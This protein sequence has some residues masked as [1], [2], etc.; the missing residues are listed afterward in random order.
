MKIVIA[1][2]S[3]KESMTA[4][5]VAN[6]IESG[7]KQVFPQAEYIKIPMADGGEGTVQSIV[8]ATKGHI[9]KLEVTGPLG[10]PLEA[11]YGLS[12]DNSLA[13]IEM[14]ASS[15]L[16]KVP[17][18]K[19]NPL[20]TTTWGLGELIKDALDEGV[21]EIIL[22]LG[23]SATIDGGIG[24]AQ[25]L[26][27]K[28][29][30]KNNDQIKPTGEGLEDIAKIDLSD[31]HHRI[32]EVKVRVASDVNNPLTGT[33]GAAYIYGPQKG[34]TAEQVEYLDRNL[35][36]LGECI[37]NDLGLDI[38]EMAGA[39]A[40]G[41]LGAGLVAFLN[42][43]LE[44]GGKLVSDLLNLK[45]RLEGADLVITGEGGI[46]HQTIFGKTPII[47]SRTAKKL[48]IPTIAFSGI[49]S[50]GFESI[51]SEGINAVFSIVPEL[52]S[53]DEALENGYKNLEMTAKNV[54][55]VLKLTVYLNNSYL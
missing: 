24:M 49:I 54:A 20:K 28:I 39:G 4:L 9:K 38:E 42:A 14:A 2:D 16:D 12:E 3:F 7:F 52:T 5:E 18:K 36:R 10:G 32:K 41:G 6:A 25:S 27:A 11:F 37:K 30:D 19:R 55:A 15:G 33:N 23:G 34:A 50:E 1:P 17:M 51:Y 40:A 22:G 8:D 31:L 43:E 13:I 44:E 53:L 29:L 21:E 48:G 26:G 47:V 46:N 45:S 35:S